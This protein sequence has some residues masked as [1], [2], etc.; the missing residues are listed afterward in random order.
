M[1]LIGK[2]LG[3]HE[4]DPYTAGI[5]LYEAGRFAEAA[6]ALRDAAQK[7]KRTAAGSLAAFYRRQALTSEGRRLLRA[8]QPAAAIPFLSEAVE[9]WGDFPDL[10]GLLGAAKGLSGDWDGALAA[11]AV[12]LRGNADYVE[13]RLLEA[14][15]L[16]ALGRKREAA[17]SLDKLVESG[18]RVDHP[19]ITELARAGGYAEQ[20]VPADLADRLARAAAGP[21]Q[22]VD[23]AAA[24]ALCRGGRWEEGVARLREYCAARPDYPD[25][26]VK[27]AA[28]LFQTGA[29]SEAL[30]EVEQALRLNPRYRTAAHLKALILADAGRFTEARGVI[31]GA[32]VQKG[33][34]P[35]NPHEELFSAYLGGVLAV[36]T[37]RPE[38]ALAGL[39]GWEDLTIAFPRAELLRAAAEDLLGRPQAAGARL[40]ALAAAWP[41]DAD[42]QYLHACRL[43]R[44]G[45]AAAVARLLGRWPSGDADAPDER[46]LL[47][48][49]HLALARGG[50]PSPPA[51]VGRS[52]SRADRFLAARSAAQ[53][54]DW[55]AC[56]RE[57][58]A[59]VREECVTERVV[60][61]LAAA[62][63]AGV[64]GPAP[65][66][67]WSPPAVVPESLVPY[68]LALR[69][70]QGRHAEAAR[71]G[72]LHRE[73]HGEDLRWTW[74]WPAFW[75]APIRRWIG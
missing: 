44:Q 59:L 19:L 18:R 25:Y 56:R 32:A 45:D 28:A 33:G 12:A 70:R 43:L 22:E 49:G 11:A 30:A 63:A 47:L 53:R 29:D 55:E 16:A 75:L 58:E 69:Y 3:R 17:A 54:G 4:S 13:A 38:E 23:V 21:P 67:P 52:E 39:S 50:A 5:A 6:D 68:V 61:L 20:T 48:A 72:D 35:L 64:E 62:E 60:L 51:A 46:P 26:R 42:Y 14:T 9:S 10:Q 71:L 27:L 24:V 74:M 8:G 41:A 73:L 40:A 65:A 1:S 2:L 66:G 15:A 57:V 31:A 37:G 34:H 36:L 7:Q